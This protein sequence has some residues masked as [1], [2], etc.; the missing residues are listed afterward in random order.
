MPKILYT[1]LSIH[2][3]NYSVSWA[4]ST[5][6]VFHLLYEALLLL[7]NS[8]VEV[9]NYKTPLLWLYS[10]KMQHE[11][12]RCCI[13]ALYL[14]LRGHDMIFL[15]MWI[16]K[17]LLSVDPNLLID[18]LVI[19]LKPLFNETLLHI[20]KNYYVLGQWLLNITKNLLRY[21]IVCMYSVYG[22]VTFIYHLYCKWM[23]CFFRHE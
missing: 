9:Q 16:C 5:V 20:S 10:R 22:T 2:F 3:T 13:F 15:N 1:I 21:C 6:H 17:I 4:P 7:S 23:N 19:T 12:V 18:L 11:L 8:I 14:F